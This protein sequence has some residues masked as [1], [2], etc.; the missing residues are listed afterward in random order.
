MNICI[1]SIKKVRPV[2]VHLLSDIKI[3]Q[4]PDRHL[5]RTSP[6]RRLELDL[7]HTALSNPLSSQEICRISD[8]Y[9]QPAKTSKVILY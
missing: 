6:G 2:H 8:G 4:D 5:P 3:I 9:L 7:Y 1:H